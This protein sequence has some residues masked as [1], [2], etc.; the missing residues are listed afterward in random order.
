P[1]KLPSKQLAH[2]IKNIGVLEMQQMAAVIKGKAAD[3][4]GTAKPP[5]SFS[6]SKTR[7]ETPFCLKCHAALRPAIPAPKIRTFF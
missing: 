5:T 2:E 3:P 7:Q 6:F 4:L 1:D